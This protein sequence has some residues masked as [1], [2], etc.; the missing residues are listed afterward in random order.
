MID[1]KLKLVKNFFQD[2]KPILIGGGVIFLLLILG[3]AFYIGQAMK[4][5]KVQQLELQVSFRK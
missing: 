5:D 2:R 4:K 3:V 1:K